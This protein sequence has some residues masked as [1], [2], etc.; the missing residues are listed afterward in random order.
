[1]SFFL[2]TDGIKNDYIRFEYVG[3][4]NKQMHVIYISKKP[5]SHSDQ[6]ITIESDDMTFNYIVYNNEYL[7]IKKAINSTAHKIFEEKDN[8]GFKITFREKDSLVSYFITR[9][10]SNSLFLK[11]NAYLK[12][13]KKNKDLIHALYIL[14]IG[15]VFDDSGRYIGG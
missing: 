11:A 8:N 2:I 3:S 5:I 6:I 7:F 13:R 1:M 9:K 10:N 12:H 15:N 14:R 4:A